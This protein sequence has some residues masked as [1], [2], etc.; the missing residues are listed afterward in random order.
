MQ[1]ALCTPHL[2]YNLVGPFLEAYFGYEFIRFAKGNNEPEASRRA[3][4]EF[5]NMKFYEGVNIWEFHDDDKI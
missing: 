5:Q 3:N 1:H 4:F 2:S